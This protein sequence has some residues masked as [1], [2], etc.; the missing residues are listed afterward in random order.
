MGSQGYQA[1]EHN[2]FFDSHRSLSRDMRMQL[3][4]N[5]SKMKPSEQWT[6]EIAPLVSIVAPVH[7]SPWQAAPQAVS[8]ECLLNWCSPKPAKLIIMGTPVP[9]NQQTSVNKAK[10]LRAV[11]KS[12][13]APWWLFR[14][15]PD[16]SQGGHFIGSRK[17]V[18]WLAK[19]WLRFGFTTPEPAMQ[20]FTQPYKMNGTTNDIHHIPFVNHINLICQQCK[21]SSCHGFQRECRTTIDPHE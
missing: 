6:R 14:T 18:G 10:P 2:Q 8:F 7:V 20:R 4:T 21:Q 19:W 9:W 15:I 1:A 3:S 12:Q 16:Y 17:T 13:A 5:N 11:P